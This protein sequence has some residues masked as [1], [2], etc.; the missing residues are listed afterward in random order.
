MVYTDSYELVTAGG[1]G[2]AAYDVNCTECVFDSLSGG[3]GGSWNG[4]NGSGNANP[5]SNA[6]YGGKGAYQYS[7]GTGGHYPPNYNGMPGSSGLG[8]SAGAK[9]C[10][11]GGGGGY[12]GGGGGAYTG[13]G[14]GSSGILST[15]V[16]GLTI[17]ADTYL[18]GVNGGNGYVIVSYTSS[19]ATD[20]DTSSNSNDDHPT[21]ANGPVIIGSIVVVIVFLC[22]LCVCLYFWRLRRNRK[23]AALLDSQLSHQQEPTAPPAAYGVSSPHVVTSPYVPPQSSYYTTSG[24]SGSGALDKNRLSQQTTTSPMAEAHVVDGGRMSDFAGSPVVATK[25]DDGHPL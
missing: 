10:G 3:Q 12:Y 23:E 1:G 15:P 21:G 4:I 24:N 19:V 22:G 6:S 8:G 5:M 16:T 25:L 2:G 14:G 13:G 11:G 9:S 20:D 18:G 17:V 7:G